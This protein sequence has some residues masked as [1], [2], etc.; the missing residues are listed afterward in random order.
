M[1]ELFTDCVPA[2]DAPGR[3]ERARISGLEKANHIHDRLQQELGCLHTIET[4]GRPDR[5]MPLAFPFTAAAWNL[6]RGLFPHESAS[7]LAAENAAVVMLSEMD[8]GMARTA[9]RHPTAEIAGD[10]AMAYAYGVEFIELGLGN[11]A[12][13]PF[14]TDDFNARG[15]HGNALLA[16]TPLVSPFMLPLSGDPIWFSRDKDQPRIGAR[17]AIGAQIETAQ[18]PLVALSTHLESHGDIALRERQMADIFALVDWHFSGLP[19]LI[20]GDLNTVNRSG[21]DPDVE[22]LF[23]LA[24]D[25]GYERHGGPAD[26]MTTRPSL[27]SEQHPKPMKLD[28]FLSR[29]LDI[30]E[31]RV[32]DALDTDG[33]P[34]SDHDLLICTVAGVRS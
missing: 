31:S 7:R 13:R 1:P 11:A 17:M 34:L 27:I 30:S 26:R 12:E 25:K 20:G 24:A 2:L 28:W 3:A 10:L 4:G 29:G 33:K 5:D 23:S 18:G 19:V 8:N 15:F 32:I 21:D 9:Q 6:Q 22:T 14:C 16:R